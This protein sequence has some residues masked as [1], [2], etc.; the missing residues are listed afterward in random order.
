MPDK[1]RLDK[2]LDN[3]LFE[4]PE[5]EEPEEESPV[6]KKNPNLS[7]AEKEK[8]VKEKDLEDVDKKDLGDKEEDDEEE[9]TK[10]DTV[11][12]IKLNNN[13]EGGGQI[14][15][16]DK[17]KI[18]SL[19]SIE[20]ILTMFKIDAENPAKGFKDKMEITIN[21]PLSDFKEHEYVITLMDKIGQLSI[22]RPDFKT[23]ITK[24]S[25]GMGGNLGQA[26]EQ[27]V[28]EEPEEA[29]KPEVDLSYLP[30]LNSEF[31]KAVKNEF[32]DKILERR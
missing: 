6:T 25:T 29:A 19:I 23:T 18:S 22:S 9:A 20:N 15:L 7:T 30:E 31:L 28:G 8:D 17:N 26:V 24:K 12:S 14:K 27:G 21:S 4:Q 13:I 1:K 16:I 32:F 5:E 10:G 2:L 11:A 3:Y